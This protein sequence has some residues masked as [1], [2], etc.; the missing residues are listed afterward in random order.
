MSPDGRRLAYALLEG[1]DY[2]IWIYDTVTRTNTRVS[3]GSGDD[4]SPVWT[5]DGAALVYNSTGGPLVWH[6]LDGTSAA[7]PLL[8]AVA[9]P[10]SFAADGWRTGRA[11]RRS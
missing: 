1:S 4:G 9:V 6:A 2:D 7:T 8:P 3:T 10:S 5:P 11:P